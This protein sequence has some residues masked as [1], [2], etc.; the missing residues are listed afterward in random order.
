MKCFRW[1]IIW[2]VISCVI[3]TL[4]GIISIKYLG[5]D[6]LIEEAAEVVIKSETG[7]DIDLSPT[8]TTK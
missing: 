8:E 6:N 1:N 3:A 2:I 5:N 7:V 4:V